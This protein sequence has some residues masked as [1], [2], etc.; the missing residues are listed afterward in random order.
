LDDPAKLQVPS[1]W[2][3]VESVVVLRRMIRP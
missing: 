3:V 2:L 1:E